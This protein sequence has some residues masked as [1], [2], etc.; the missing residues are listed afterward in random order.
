MGRR[1]HPRYS[2][3]M[4]QLN[5]TLWNIRKKVGDANIAGT[6]RTLEQFAPEFLEEVVEQ[7]AA[8]NNYTANLEEA[9]VAIVVSN[10]VKK[11][12]FYHDAEQRGEVITG[13]KGGRKV[14]L[15]KLRHKVKSWKNNE[16][17][18]RL[19]GRIYPKGTQYK[20]VNGT[21]VRVRPNIPGARVADAYM[22]DKE[23][24]RGLHQRLRGEE[25]APRPYRYLKKWENEAGYRNRANKAIRAAGNR[26]GGYK[27][28][29]GKYHTGTTRSFIRIVNVAPY[30]Q[31]VQSG[32]NRK[33]H[34]NVLRGALINR[35]GQMYK[36]VLM[37]ELKARGFRAPKYTR[38]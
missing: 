2:F 26:A 29:K 36:D 20:I 11:R 18:R 13:P 16:K 5:L 8:F 19:G 37:E 31:Y 23:I 4:R 17:Y 35:V 28:Y 14:Y 30:A 25:T 9:Y 27:D 38:K 34:Q 10:G 12:I 15:T 22:L 21:F 33:Y 32:K 24:G 3:G 7:E 6:K 1:A